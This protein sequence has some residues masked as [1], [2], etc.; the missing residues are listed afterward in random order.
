MKKAL[1]LVLALLCLVALFTACKK[2]ET[3]D[4]TPNPPEG[5]TQQ[6][7]ADDAQNTPPAF[8]ATLP[9]RVWTLNGTT[10]F[11]M[12]PLISG[13]NDGTA[14]LNYQFT[15]ETNAVN[16]RDAVIN[17]TA[18][19]AA[20]PTNVASALYRA[21][22]GG[23]KVLAINTAGVLYLITNTSNGAEA[24]SLA[25]LS[26]KTVYCPAQNPA[27]IVKALI[28]R[29]GV[30]GITLDST[31]YADPTDLR[32]AI[33]SGLVDYAILPEPMVTIAKSA[34]AQEERTLTVSLDLTAEW[35][36]YFPAGSL[37]QGC[38]VVRNE[39]LTAHPAE[40][41]KFMEEY[42]A[43]ITYVNEQPESASQMIATSGIFAQA[44]VAKQAIPKCNICYIA[45]AQM[46]AALSAFL[47]EMPLN[48]IGGALP[49]DDFYYGA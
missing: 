14:A 6:T 48:S 37:V 32:T 21:T 47:A 22:G 25:D 18:D 28:D 10:G 30:T 29:S 31:T 39:F 20:V 27:F 40:V 41:A 46:K 7:P 2:Q 13:K 33:A 38:V 5:G 3:P 26:G 15:V 8:D 16:V 34:A 42:R 9:V 23:V 36:K 35:N 49:G 19:I 45:G 24:S 44:A 12:A 4:E 11:G 17:G 1:A 43:S